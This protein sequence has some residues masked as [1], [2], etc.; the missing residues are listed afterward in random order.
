MKKP[1]VLKSILLMVFMGINTMAFSQTTGSYDTTVTF[2]GA[3]RA[4]SFY[5]PPTYDSTLKYRLIVGLHGLGDNSS[6]YRNALVSGLGWAASIPNTIFICPEAATVNSDYY[7]P[8]GNEAIIQSA[9]DLAMQKYHIDTNNVVL[10]G[11]SLGGRA[12]LRYGLDNYAK[13]KGL[14]LNTPAI[15]GVKNAING[16]PAYS[17]NYAN[18]VH[19][20]IYITHG[21][22][23]IIYKAPLDS[24]YEQLII[25]NSK[26]RYY[27]FPGL[28]HTIPPIA[29]I[30]NFIPFFDTPAT[31]GYDLDVVKPIIT[32]RSCVTSVPASC[33]IRNTGSSTIHSANL[34]YTV[35]G[36]PLNYV[37]TGSLTSFQHAVVSLPT[38][39]APVG[40]D[41]LDVKVTML[42][43]TVADTITFNNEK[44]VPFQVKTTGVALPLTEGFEG[45]FP[46]VD[47]IQYLAGDAY[48]PWAADSTTFK[49][50]IAS[51]GTFNTILIFDNSGRKED[52]A[53]PLLDLT[54]IANPYLTFDVAYNY[55]HYAP[56][57]TTIDTIFADTLEV[58]ISTDC[59]AT[60]T[61]LYKKGGTQLATFASPILNPTSIAADFIVPADSN[62]RTEGIDLSAYSTD[63]KAIVKFSYI[64]A[65]GGSINID[66]V[67]FRGN[68]VK[69]EQLQL[70]H[71]GNVF[72]N[73][74][75]D[76]VLV[77]AGNSVLD[78]I[79]IVDMTGKTVMLVNC[80]QGRTEMQ[81]NIASLIEGVYIL[82]AY[83]DHG[84]EHSRMVISR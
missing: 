28:G 47:W 75:N 79:A 43:T 21:M 78:H 53:S 55:H 5:V 60:Y 7:Y 74:A 65:L 70:L 52:I 84:I 40:N 27:E 44:K 10:Q 66:N 76:H 58:L 42:D 16:L 32:Q 2:L 12:A 8:A 14:L 62:W 25:N 33:L 31:H 13:F 18:G 56:P 41:T 45:V 23:D 81:V 39:T 38:L 63:N 57:V 54:S 19:I 64:S 6:N 46:P 72:P 67:K 50:G 36:V 17:F 9:I 71:A 37:W 15:Q 1:S 34:Q 61:S 77:T 35:A 22:N 11:F 20:P 68:P 49:T 73:P 51:M 4:M 82:L 80:E 26:V 48:S 24:A 59:G 3:S 83:T 30:V 29:S 69:T